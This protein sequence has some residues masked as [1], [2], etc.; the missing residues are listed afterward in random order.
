MKLYETLNLGSRKCGTEPEAIKNVVRQ[1][2]QNVINLKVRKS[3]RLQ[4]YQ[5]RLSYAASLCFLDASSCFFDA[6]LL[7]FRAFSML[8]C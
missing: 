8:S 4:D 5:F 3:N 2:K 6:L 7:S 1:L